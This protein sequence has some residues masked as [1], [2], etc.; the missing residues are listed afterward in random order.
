MSPA[1]SARFERDRII[2]RFDPDEIA[3]PGE[4]QSGEL[5]ECV[6]RRP[7]IRQALASVGARRVS[8]LLKWRR[9]HETT[10][11]NRIGERIRLEDLSGLMVVELPPG[12]DVEV[13]A[14]RLALEGGVRYAHPNAIPEPQ[15]VPNDSLFGLQWYLHS[16]GQS[17]CGYTVAPNADINA[18]EAW[19]VWT[20]AGHPIRVGIVERSIQGD[21]PDLAPRVVAAPFGSALCEGCEN[22]DPLVAVEPHGTAVAGLVAASGGNLLG[23][24]GVN[25][26]ATLVAMSYVGEVEVAAQLDWARAH[27]VQVVNLSLGSYSSIY[28]FEALR[29]VLLDALRSGVL[30]VAAMGNSNVESFWPA[31]YATRTYAV[32]ALGTEGFRWRDSDYAGSGQAQESNIG[33]YIDVSAPA[34]IAVVTTKPGS[35][36]FRL[37]DCIY[38]SVDYFCC[39]SAATPVVS[40]VASLVLSY[41]PKLLGE[42]LQHIL[43]SSALD[44]AGTSPTGEFH[45]VGWDSLTGHGMVRAREALDKLTGK[46]VFQ[47]QATGLSADA[48]SSVS[49]TIYNSPDAV[50]NGTHSARRYRLSKSVSFNGTF[51]ALPEAWTRGSGTAGTSSSLSHDYNE[52]IPEAAIVAGSLTTNGCTVESYVF[53][54]L[55]GSGQTLGWY[56]CTIQDATI[57][58]T[59]LGPGTDVTAPSQTTDLAI[60]YVSSTEIH[61]RWTASGDDGMS[62]RAFAYDL[63][64]ANTAINSEAK[65]S[66]ATPVITPAPLIGGSAQT[67][68][69]SN[70]A[71]CTWNYFALKT[72]D[73]VGWVSARST[74]SPGA[75]TLCAPGSR[76]EQQTEEPGAGV[77][78]SSSRAIVFLL[79]D[80]LS[81]GLAQLQ[82]FDVAGRRIARAEVLVTTGLN[83]IPL[84]TALEGAH[85]PR[86]GV[87]LARL[88]VAGRSWVR[89]MA[90]VPDAEVKP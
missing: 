55:N 86:S 71:P 13:A 12:A 15:G 90:F 77:G 82:L 64:R 23:G 6:I 7:A 80:D 52:E 73:Q 85:P 22:L 56:P 43:N 27:D 50:V 79:P 51:T 62:G 2:V 48:P 26:G 63:R 40:G 41:R 3:F 67:L 81:S 11:F 57:G 68:V 17:V 76:A 60:D 66:A 88:E 42:D 54:V 19:D 46:A 20:G 1:S 16:I 74:T 65:F 89:R 59:A 5:A 58:V 83:R 69:V 49:V 87:Y 9:P 38:P 14:R 32:G 18:P 84:S 47:S 75:K 35:D 37:L 72:V 53:E 8:R 45:P 33:T 34:G 28:P 44:I 24:S 31:A 10:G 39:T 78:A 30:V 61:L 25:W 21:H 36:Y 70:L 4:A 29:E